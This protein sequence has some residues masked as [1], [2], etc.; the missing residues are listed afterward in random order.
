MKCQHQQRCHAPQMGQ[1]RIPGEV[2]R[3]RGKSGR[4]HGDKM[5][6]RMRGVMNSS[7]RC[8]GDETGSLHAGKCIPFKKMTRFF[9]A[10]TRLA[11]AASACVHSSSMPLLTQRRDC[12]FCMPQALRAINLRIQSPGEPQATWPCGALVVGRCS[13]FYTTAE[14]FP[15]HWARFLGLTGLKES[16]Y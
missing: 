7:R 4:R 1:T 6:K 11:S 15:G 3:V 2:G 5:Q 8:A 13:L 12:I 9:N 16:A 14:L 10:I